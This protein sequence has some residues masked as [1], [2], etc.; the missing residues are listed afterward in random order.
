MQKEGGLQYNQK[1]AKSS[2]AEKNIG[3]NVSKNVVKKNSQN[4]V[5]FL[6]IR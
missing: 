2:L 1:S 3:K 4:L 6:P 5:T